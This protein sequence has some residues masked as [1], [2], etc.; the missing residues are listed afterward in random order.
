MPLEGQSRARITDTAIELP[1]GSQ[2]SGNKFVFVE[3]KF[4]DYNGTLATQPRQ[5]NASTS[6]PAPQPPPEQKKSQ[7]TLAAGAPQCSSF[8]SAVKVEAVM[9][10]RN[11]LA[12]D[13]VLQ[14]EGC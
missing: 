14:R 13:S 6:S 4:L 1:I 9:R 5:V 11:S 12:I 10:S 7:Y 8:K 3:G 2:G